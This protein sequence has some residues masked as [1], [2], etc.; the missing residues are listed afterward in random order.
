MYFS[1]RQLSIALTIVCGAFATQ[2]LSARPVV[3]HEQARVS[4]PQPYYGMFDVCLRGDDMLALTGRP[5]PVSQSASM[6]AFVHFKKQASGE[7]QLVEEVFAESYEWS[8]YWT[9]ED[10]VCEGDLAAFSGP[11]RFSIIFELTA[12][13]WQANPIHLG[14]DYPSAV[15]IHGD[16]VAF[17]EFLRDCAPGLRPLVARYLVQRANL[18]YASLHRDLLD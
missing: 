11:D 15:A 6:W 9:S 1:A 8:D 13:G 16:T 5:D 17:S 3:L 18:P 4:L 10:F 2:V 7:W 12:A 14:S